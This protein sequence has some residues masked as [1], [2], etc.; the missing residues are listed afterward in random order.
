[1]IIKPGEIYKHYKGNYYLIKSLAK[2]SETKEDMVVYE[3]NRHKVWVRPLKEFFEIVENRNG[4]QVSR[5]SLFQ[6]NFW[7]Y[8]DDNEYDRIDAASKVLEQ[9]IRINELEEA[10]GIFVNIALP[11][12]KPNERCANLT[13][14]LSDIYKARKAY[15]GD[16]YDEKENTCESKYKKCTC[17]N[18]E[19]DFWSRQFSDMLGEQIK[20][21]DANCP[22]HGGR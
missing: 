7:R 1:M 3:S 4:E 9:Q 19:L 21:I 12:I 17:N 11:V 5:F 2:N 15:F 6:T 13:V 14:R 18:S 22:E 10:L 8:E 20:C 16:L